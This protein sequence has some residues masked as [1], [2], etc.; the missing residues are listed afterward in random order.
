MNFYESKIFVD[1]IEF[2]GDRNSYPIYDEDENEIDNGMF[3]R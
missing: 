1:D 3:V 2:D